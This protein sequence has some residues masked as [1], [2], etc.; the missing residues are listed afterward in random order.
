MALSANEKY[1]YQMSFPSV[2]AFNDWYNEANAAWL[3]QQDREEL[4][5]D[6]GAD[7]D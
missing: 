4:D 5:P 1:A 6:H 7:L 3:A 2:K